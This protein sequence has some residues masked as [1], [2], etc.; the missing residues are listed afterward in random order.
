MQPQLRAKSDPRDSVLLPAPRSQGSGSSNLS[1]QIGL[2]PSFWLQRAVLRVSKILPATPPPSGLGCFARAQQ[3]V[4]SCTLLRH[5]ALVST[6][7]RRLTLGGR[8]SKQ[9]PSTVLQPSSGN[10]GRSTHSPEPALSI[11]APEL[12]RRPGEGSMEWQAQLRDHPAAVSLP[13]PGST[14]SWMR[15]LKASGPGFKTLWTASL[16]VPLSAIGSQTHQVL[17]ILESSL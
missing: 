3:T 12:S 4:F 1:G 10:T 15:C 9:V 16:L 7:S 11:Y 2:R 6:G 14:F 8:V 13:D 17:E 5:S